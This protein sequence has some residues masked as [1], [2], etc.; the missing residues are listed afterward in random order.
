MNTCVLDVAVALSGK[1]FSKIR[2][3]LVLQNQYC[4]Q[5]GSDIL[6]GFQ[7]LMY[8]TMGSQLQI[9]N[10]DNIREGENEHPPSFV[11]NLVAV[12]RS[13]NNVQTQ[14][15]AILRYDY[16]SQTL[17]WSQIPIDLGPKT[18]HAK[19][20]ESLSSDA[21]AHHAPAGPSSQ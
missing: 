21:Q 16:A 10:R 19:Q 3:V 12:A 13:V 5:T 15:N 7:T 20:S 17:R 1:L 9:E 8:L 18:Y 11:V 4:E 6:L 2:R 14:P